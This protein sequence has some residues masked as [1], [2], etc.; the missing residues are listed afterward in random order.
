M[1]YVLLIVWYLFW[2]EASVTWNPTLSIMHTSMEC[3]FFLRLLLLGV[4]LL[5]FYILKNKDNIHVLGRHP[6]TETRITRICN[7]C[8]WSVKQYLIRSET[9]RCKENGEQKSVC[10]I[11][12]SYMF[13]PKKIIYCHH[14]IIYMIHTKPLLGDQSSHK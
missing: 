10:A 4:R 9:F 11:L 2:L 14:H 12:S 13:F 1:A 5:A 3:Y 7:R 6:L 8:L